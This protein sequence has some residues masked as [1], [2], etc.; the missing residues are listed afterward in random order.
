TV[1]DSIKDGITALS[2]QLAYYFFLALFPA[3]LF[4]VALASFFPLQNAIDE[5]TNALARFAPGDVLAIVEGQ[6]KAISNDRNTGLL[7]IGF[8]GTLWSTSTA[9]TGIID[10][11][12]KAYGIEEGRSWW[13]VRLTAIAL[14]VAVGLFVLIS[15]TLIVVGPQLAEPLAEYFGLGG[16]FATTWKIV[17]WPIVFL[18]VSIAIG[19]IYYFGPDAEQEWEWL[20]PGSLVATLLWVGASLGFRF[21]VTSFG[22][23]NETYG[24]IGGVII[25]LLWLYITGLSILFGAEL[26]AE[27]EH[28]SPH[29]KEVGE[30]RPGEKRKLGRLAAAEHERRKAEDGRRERSRLPRAPVAAPAPL[31]FDADASRGAEREASGGRVSRWLLGGLVLGAKLWS[32]RKRGTRA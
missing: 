4:L 23:Y 7:T 29:G 31:A 18:L 12:N 17:Q 28:A 6:L 27:I 9:M 22:N 16:A 8:L 11:L 26:N 2:A 30:K 14:T 15:F 25:A 32:G 20:T 21:Y 1:N 5:I 3:L 24:T 10:T 13:K 19:F